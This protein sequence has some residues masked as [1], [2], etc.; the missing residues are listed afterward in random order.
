MG[1]GRSG[2]SREGTGR[3]DFP[4]GV[5]SSIRDV[6]FAGCSRSRSESGAKAS[7]AA[8]SVRAANTLLVRKPGN[9]G[10]R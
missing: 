6:E 1:A 5:I 9:R 2:Q 8:C 4:N 10:R 7:V 3:G